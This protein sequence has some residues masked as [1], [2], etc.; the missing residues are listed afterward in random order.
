MYYNDR[1]K[2][3]ISILFTTTSNISIKWLFTKTQMICISIYILIFVIQCWYDSIFFIILS[4]TLDI[5][6]R[7]PVWNV[8]RN[9][10]K[11]TMQWSIYHQF[12]TGLTWSNISKMC[13][14]TSYYCFNKSNKYYNKSGSYKKKIRSVIYEVWHFIHMWKALALPHYVTK[15]RGC[16]P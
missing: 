14:N 1:T 15:R 4:R 2:K 3:N 16:G 11:N 12:E 6:P 7:G 13:I 5:A 8:S 9:D 10:M